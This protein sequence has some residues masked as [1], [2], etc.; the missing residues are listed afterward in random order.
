M[1]LSFIASAISGAV[2]CGESDEPKWVIWEMILLGLVEGY[3]FLVS[4]MDI[5]EDG[6]TVIGGMDCSEYPKEKCKGV[7]GPMVARKSSA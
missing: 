3:E 5:Y 4:F 6:R 1:I 7:D 2:H